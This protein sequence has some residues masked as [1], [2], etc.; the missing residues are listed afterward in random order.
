MLK[1]LSSCTKR[2]TPF[3][4]GFYHG[5]FYILIHYRRGRDRYALPG[6]ACGP[7]LLRGQKVLKKAH[8]YGLS[9]PLE[10]EKQLEQLKGRSEKLA[11]GPLL[12]ALL[13]RLG[14]ACDDVEEALQQEID[15]YIELCARQEAVRNSSE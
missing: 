7:A 13:E 9:Q 4:P 3:M 12:L 15:Q 14:S 6:A 11:V 5:T 8:K 10:L 2:I 1:A